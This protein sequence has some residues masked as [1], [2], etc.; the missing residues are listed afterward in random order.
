M[1]H[2]FTAASGPDYVSR[3]EMA[4]AIDD[5]ERFLLDL[6]MSQW[7]EVVWLR[8]LLGLTGVALFLVTLAVAL[9]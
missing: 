6:I 5:R 7:R 9:R 3:E 2:E 1:I 4:D 8:G